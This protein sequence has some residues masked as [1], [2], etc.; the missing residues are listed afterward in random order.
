M[1]IKLTCTNCKKEHIHY[2]KYQEHECPYCKGKILK[3]TKD[4]PFDVLNQEE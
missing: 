3:M 2:P 1:R 4:Q